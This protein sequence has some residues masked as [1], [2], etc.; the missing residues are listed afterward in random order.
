[1]DISVR[2][3][4]QD[5]RISI[6]HDGRR[7]DPACQHAPGERGR[8]GGGEHP[9][10]RQRTGEPR[11]ARHAPRP[12]STC[13]VGWWRAAKASSSRPGRPGAERAPPCSRPCRSSIATRERR[14]A[15]GPGGVPVPGASQIQV[16]RPAGLG[17]P[18]ALR[19]VLRQDPDVV[20]VGEIRDR[21]TA[22][23]AMTAAVTGHLVLSTIHTTDAPGAVTRL[24]D[25]GVPPSWSPGGCRAWWRRGWCVGLARSAAHADATSAATGMRGAPVSSR[26]WR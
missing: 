22:E 23:I 15:R 12:I 2:R 11:G 20:M 9:G 14:D 8:E 5:G 25:M 19:A 13:S 3:R 18:E 26:C 6:T 1:M 4:A 17:F 10:L 21:E 16:D 7:P 24:L